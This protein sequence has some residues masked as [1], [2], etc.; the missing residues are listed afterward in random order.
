MLLSQKILS[1][2][3]QL[4]LDT[5]L[6]AGIEVMNPFPDAATFGL[7]QQFYTKYYNDSNPR[8]LILGIN[9]GRFGGGITGIPFTDPIRLQKICGVENDFQKKQELSSVFVYEVIKSFGGAQ[10]FYDKFYIS[11]ISPLGFINNNKNLN[12]YD[13]R[14]LENGIKS[15]VIDCLRKQIKFGI[16]TDVVYCFGEGKNAAYLTRLNNEMNFFDKIVP[17][18]HPRF[19][20]QYKLK[21]KDEYID[22]YL[23]ELQSA[24]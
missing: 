16:S 1:F 11:S 14:Q 5:K 22:K 23:R 7:C 8:H 12:Y 9:P 2:L 3:K 24:R 6:P 10:T 19:I 4:H 18:P 15:F 13:D 17:L 21:K 20:M